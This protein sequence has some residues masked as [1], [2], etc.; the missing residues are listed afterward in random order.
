[1]VVVEL[2][3][4]LLVEISAAETPPVI[5]NSTDNKRKLLHAVVAVDFRLALHVGPC[6][7]GIVSI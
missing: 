6:C 1:M 4:E 3:L 7:I 5:D 2:V